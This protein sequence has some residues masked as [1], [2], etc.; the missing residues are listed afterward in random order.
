MN[1]EQ[2]KQKKKQ[3]EKMSKKQK[4]RSESCETETEIIQVESGESVLSEGSESEK[5]QC[6]ET[7]NGT[8]RDSFI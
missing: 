5:A 6:K 4:S 8:L 2:K 7:I 1:C 3:K